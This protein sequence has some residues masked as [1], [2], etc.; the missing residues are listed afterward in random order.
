MRNKDLFVQSETEWVLADLSDLATMHNGTADGMYV[1][2]QAC[3]HSDT[4][5]GKHTIKLT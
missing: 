4:R 3:V 5:Y 2:H 1:I